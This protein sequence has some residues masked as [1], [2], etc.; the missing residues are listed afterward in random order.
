[1]PEW[2]IGA[3]L[4]T[5]VGQP[6]ESSNLSPSAIKKTKILPEGSIFVFKGAL[7]VGN[8]GECYLPRMCGRVIAEI[9]SIYT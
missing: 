3:V 5:V 1:M 2:F 9:K 8:L 6:T 4:K 7:K